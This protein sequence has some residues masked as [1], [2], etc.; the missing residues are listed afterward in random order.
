MSKK[1][2]ALI[3]CKVWTL[4]WAVYFKM[5]FQKNF[6]NLPICFL[7]L[8]SIWLYTLL[9]FLIY[10]LNLN[11][12]PSLKLNSPNNNF[13][14][15]LFHVLMSLHRLFWPSFRTSIS[16]S[17]SLHPSS[18]ISLTCFN[19][20]LYSSAQCLGMSL[21]QSTCMVGFCRHFKSPRSRH[22]L[23]LLLLLLFI[24][25]MQSFIGLLLYNNIQPSRQQMDCGSDHVSTLDHAN[26]ANP[27]H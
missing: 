14:L 10:L 4:L 12:T 7:T 9:Y 2:L 20:G 22:L 11:F 17:F 26:A 19:Y 3:C 15:C 6:A 18:A 23:L 1:V 8:L 21:H 13:L 5:L 24:N 25:H 16:H 27:W